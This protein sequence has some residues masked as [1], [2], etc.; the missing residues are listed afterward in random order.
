LARCGF[1]GVAFFAFPAGPVKKGLGHLSQRVLAAFDS[2][3]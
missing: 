1:H 2:I 3:C